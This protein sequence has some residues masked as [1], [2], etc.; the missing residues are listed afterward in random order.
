M[1]SDTQVARCV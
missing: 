1:Y